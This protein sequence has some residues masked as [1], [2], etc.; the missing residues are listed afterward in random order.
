MMRS[1]VAFALRLGLLVV[2]AQLST[3]C[4]GNAKPPKR[5]VIESDVDNWGF[6]RYQS[7]L[8]IEVWVAKNE[9]VAHTASYARKTS[10]KKGRIADKDVINAFVTRY[11]K[12]RGIRRALVVF[13]HRLAQQS[14]YKVEEKKRSGVRVFQVV[15][16]SERWVFWSSKGHVVKLGGPGVTSIPGDLIDAYA[17]RYPSNLKSG[18]LEGPL[19]DEPEEAVIKTESIDGE[20][21]DGDSGD[22]EEGF[23]DDDDEEGLEDEDEA[24]KPEWQ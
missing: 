9:A 3:G 7:V 13:A 17:E 18:S 22:E 20:G 4:G 1:S 21:G 6:R 11:E 19:P 2:A 14:G 12:R 5:G 10:E 15:G 24:P 8:D 23:E 16:P